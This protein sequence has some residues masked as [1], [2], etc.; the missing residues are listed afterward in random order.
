[1]SLF[2]AVFRVSLQ[3]K[4]SP[5]IISFTMA[6]DDIDTVDPWSPGYVTPASTPSPSG[7]WSRGSPGGPGGARLGDDGKEAVLMFP[8][9]A[10]ARA[11]ADVAV[12]VRQGHHT[13]VNYSLNDI[14]TGK[15]SSHQVLS[16]FNMTVRQGSIYALLGASGC[17]KTT[18]LRAMVGQHKL[19]S[20]SVS[21]FGKEPRTPGIGI[22][23]PSL[24]YMPQELAVPDGFTIRETLNYFG[25]LAG[26]SN[27]S[28]EKQRAILLKLLDLPSEHRL[29]CNLSG[30]QQRRVSLA[31]ALLHQPPLLIL[32]EPTVGVDSI[33]RQSIWDHLLHLT[34]CGRTTVIITTHYI[35]EARQAHVV[36]LMRRGAL[37]A[38][39]T[40]DHLL[41]AL[42]C[43]TLE[44]VLLKLCLAQDSNDP[45]GDH[46]QRAL[47]ASG[48]RM[49]HEVDA[50]RDGSEDDPKAAKDG[51]AQ[52]AEEG[53]RAA[54]VEM[55]TSRSGSRMK[56]L[57]WKNV[58]WLWR[59]KI[60]ALA[61]TFL[62]A[63]IAL[64][65]NGGVG[66]TP[67][68]LHLAVVNHEVD[69]GAWPGLSRLNCS[70]PRGLSCI[71][72]DEMKASSLRPVV[73]PEEDAAASAVVK[74]RM[75]GVV[76]F[77]SNF[78]DSLV[79][80]AAMTINLENTPDMAE[81]A[82]VNSILEA[83]ALNVK[84]DM[85]LQTIGHLLQQRLSSVTA[86]ALEAFNN[87]CNLNAHMI[88][89]PLQFHNELRVTDEDPTFLDT[90]LSGLILSIVFMF[91]FTTTMSALLPEK[92]DKL[93][94][95][96]LV[97][98]VHMGEVLLAQFAAQLL[99][100]AA[101]ITLVLV[102]CFALFANP[103]MGPAL[104]YAL[105]CLAQGVCGM[106]YGLLTAVIFDSTTA[107][108]L[109]GVGTYFTLMFLSS[110]LWP[111]EGM[112][113]L[114]KP[115]AT[116][117]PMTTATLSLRNIALRAWGLYHP[118]VYIGFLATISWTL[119]FILLTF[120]TIKVRF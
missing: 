18:V 116:I 115:I 58:M 67:R 17:G 119:V 46:F 79:E 34:A 73:F 104:T 37:L 56:A 60:I 28:I 24:G 1:M 39:D 53:I 93:L 31:V 82:R 92:T 50:P 77:A 72:V 112:Y 86:K 81:L 10:V 108:S 83:S 40:P 89:P 49:A 98:G 106:W 69:C 45:D 113:L 110:M 74:G 66:G 6:V 55:R 120:I 12:S 63:F 43:S 26:M 3:V 64:V 68:D 27:A 70:A 100:I 2:L 51:A 71:F 7:S 65:Y 97:Y 118:G 61:F 8:M 80:R 52:D 25:W 19:T 42:S 88:R 57:L 78:S 4:H 84:L 94:E 11:G 75:W 107:A 21:V 32:D 105:L 33:V 16:D 85:S 59:H 13:Y 96:S 35:E 95:R 117:L 91:G 48:T 38:E 87:Q 5:G 102:V 29:V 44:D 101:Q 76:H 23:G 30:G 90:S 36:G 41:A 103:L 15:P 62:P 22:P 109:M 114:L 111:L 20:G 14:L 54:K 99:M 9:G 47:K